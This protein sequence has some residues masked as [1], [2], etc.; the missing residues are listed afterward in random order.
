MKI[1]VAPLNWGLGHASRCVPLIT[2]LCREGHEV[3]LGGDGDALTY[4]R[5][6]FPHLRSIELAQLN[7]RYSAGK[8]QV[9]AM[10]VAIPKLIAFSIRDH[11]LL[12]R[13]QSVEHF[14]QV[15]SDNRFG[16]YLTPTALHST[17]AQR[18]STTLNSKLSTLHCIYITHQLHI[19]L[20]RPYKWLE[21]F[22]SR[23]HAYIYNK[24]SEVWVPD[25]PDHR[26]SGEL[27]TIN[28]KLINYSTLS[29]LHSKLKYVGP[30]SRFATLNSKLAQR[31]STTLHSKLSTLNSYKAVA[32]FSGL[33]PHRTLFEQAILERFKGREQEVLLVNGKV[34]KQLSDEELAYYLLNAQTIICRSGYSTIMDLDALGVLDKAELIPTPGQP[35]QEYLAEKFAYIKKK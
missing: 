2:R 31:A 8:R 19:M 17:L 3:V 35:E 28:S 26:L 11:R 21:P 32:L 6:H 14:D 23:L 4:L 34:N 22:A 5:Q 15:I 30:L 9:L 25:T 29:T 18:A 12:K 27:S 20:P 1:L 33:E 13:L 16:L 24:Y 10:M 7:L